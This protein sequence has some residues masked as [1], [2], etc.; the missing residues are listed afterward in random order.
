M[1]RESTGCN[2]WMFVTVVPR[3]APKLHRFGAFRAGSHLRAPLLVLCSV[4]SKSAT[5][6]TRAD[7]D[8]PTC[9]R[10]CHRHR[11][12][13]VH[14]Q[15]HPSKQIRES[16]E[17]QLNCLGVRST[18]APIVSVERHLRVLCCRP[19]CQEILE[20][21]VHPSFRPL[22]RLCLLL[23]VWFFGLFS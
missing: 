8:G 4:P 12:R 14:D 11:L 9:E 15:P 17:A 7:G 6:G 20:I 18:D 2:A 23:E 16:I 22:G 13:R 21:L 5:I 19:H 3:Q 10:R 1:S